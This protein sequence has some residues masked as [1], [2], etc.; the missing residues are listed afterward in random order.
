MPEAQ[1]VT[2]IAHDYWARAI[3]LLRALPPKRRAAPPLPFR[4]LWARKIQ[5]YAS[6]ALDPSP[7][8]RVAALEQPLPGI[9]LP[10]L[11]AWWVDR[12]GVWTNPSSG[13]VLLAAGS[14]A[15]QASGSLAGA[16][17]LLLEFCEQRASDNDDAFTEADIRDAWMKLP[18]TESY[19]CPAV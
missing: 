14:R 5:L 12:S 2:L 18:V 10:T 9:P 8:D 13:F 6:A 15:I 7:V 16:H 3:W 4:K 19:E 1:D 17:R 11:L